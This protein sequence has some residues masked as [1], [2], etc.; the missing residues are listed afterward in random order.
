MGSGEELDRRA[1]RKRLRPRVADSV[2]AA[3][4]RGWT[5]RE[6]GHGVRI[7]CPGTGP[8]HLRHQMSIAGTSRSE[9]GQAKR[10]DRFVRTCT[11]SSG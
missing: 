5:V 1:V 11:I 8:E 7:Y 9:D 3:M 6:Q 4:D 10:I 2:L